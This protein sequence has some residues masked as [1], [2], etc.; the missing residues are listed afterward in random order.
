MIEEKKQA[1]LT[2]RGIACVDVLYIKLVLQLLLWPQKG[3]GHL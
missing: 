2:C 1:F 3:A